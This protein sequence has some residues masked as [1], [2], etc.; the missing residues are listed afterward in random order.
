MAARWRGAYALNVHLSGVVA[1]HFLRNRGRVIRGV[2]RQRRH[3][4]G[5]P[6]AAWSELLDRRAIYLV[7]TGRRDG[8]VSLAE[9]AIL[10]QAAAA[11]QPGTC[12]IEMGTFDGRTTVNLAVN[13]ARQIPV[14][15]LDLPWDEGALHDLVPGERQYVRKVASG[16]R[17][18]SCAW[19]WSPHARRISR[20]HGDSATFDW[21]AYYGKAGLVFIDA[22]HAYDYVCKDSEAALRM[23][24]AA[25]MIVWHDYGVWEGVTRAL[26]ELESS[27]KLGLRHIR[28]TSL[29]FWRAG[30]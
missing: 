4:T 13:A 3:P 24:A 12:V 26:E 18:Q 21:S 6:Q 1:A 22:S 25:G 28:G 16:E 23:V 2:S 11:T 29:V 30:R 27:R 15:T 8:N 9:L 5:L 17:I 14:V 20:L 7:E 19:P 10:A